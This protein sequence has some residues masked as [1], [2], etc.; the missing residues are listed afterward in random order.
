MD[1][2]LMTPTQA[3]TLLGVREN[4][5]ATWRAKRRYGLAYVRVGGRVAYRQ[6]DIEAF[7]KA[8]TVDGLNA[9]PADLKAK[10]HQPKHPRPKKPSAS[11][12]QQLKAASSRRRPKVARL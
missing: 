3:A 7:L 4:T 2:Q 6:A 10:P 8:R 9:P 1:N 12:K 5:L 11:G